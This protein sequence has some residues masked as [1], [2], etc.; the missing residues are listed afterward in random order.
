MLFGGVTSAFASGRLMPLP[1]NAGLLDDVRQAYMSGDR[2]TVRRVDELK[3]CA[4][5]FVKAKPV[6]ITDKKRVA[7]SN[8]P[9][10]YITLSPYWWPDS[11][12]NGGLPYVRRDG[13]RNPEVYEYA[14]RE[15]ANEMGR[16]VEITSVLYYITGERRYAKACAAQL[17]AWFTD[18]KTGINPNMTYSQIIPGR[19][20][21]RGTGIIDSR[22]FVK[23]VLFSQLLDDSEEWTETDRRQLKAWAE[24]YC[25]WLEHSTQGRKEAKAANNHGLWYDAIHV[26]LLAYLDREE[27]VRR[28]VKEGIMT[29]LAEQTAPDGSLPKELQR[30]LSLHYSTFVMEALVTAANVVRPAGINLWKETTA[31]GTGME[32]IAGFLMP[33]YINP[34]KWQHKQIKPFETWRGAVVMREAAINIGNKDYLRAAE[35]IKTEK[36]K[37]GID[38]L[39]YGMCEQ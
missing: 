7:P 4:G 16:R 3:A 23:A 22:R 13:K 18:A 31:E 37:A 36:M 2:E 14:D 39:V 17:R 35:K 32:T 8:D 28:A 20:G 12:R 29:K 5:K 34:E 15:S 27:D 11:T 19:T 21:L 26:M 30:T 10:D 25:Y 38:M 1:V 6:V 24:A 33:Y 9:R